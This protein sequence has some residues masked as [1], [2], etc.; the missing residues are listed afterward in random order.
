VANTHYFKDYFLRHVFIDNKDF[1]LTETV[2]GCDWKYV[3]SD[4]RIVYTNQINI[5][6]PMGFEGK[7]VTPF[8]KLI[9]DMYVSKFACVKEP[10]KF[11][12]AIGKSYEQFAGR[13]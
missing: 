8:A 13:D 1:K 12:K 2:E 5:S 10:G 6:N 4:P 3:P 7:I 11:K 9:E